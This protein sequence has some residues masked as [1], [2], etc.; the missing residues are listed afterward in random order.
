MTGL[1]SISAI[2]GCASASA[3]TRRIV[4][5]SASTSAFGAPRNPSRSGNVARDRNHLLGIDVGDGCHA[6][7]DVA[8]E[9]HRDTP[10]PAGDDGPEDRIGHHPDEH[11]DGVVDLLLHEER[12]E[13]FPG[14]LHAF[15]HAPC[16]LEHVGRRYPDPNGARLGLVQRTDPLHDDRPAERRGGL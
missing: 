14:G 1:Q 8:L 4:C 2:S 13:P 7:G 9:L 6:Y 15:P 16:F 3:P 11:L 12:L 5:T 10:A